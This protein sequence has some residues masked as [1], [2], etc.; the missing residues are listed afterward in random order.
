MFLDFVSQYYGYL[1][2][3][4][5]LGASFFAIGK[6]KAMELVKTLVTEA[7]DTLG[8]HLLTHKDQYVK[9]IYDKIPAKLKVFVSLKMIEKAIVEIAEAIDKK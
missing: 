9:A 5:V 2:A 8:E 7:A 6:K 3:A 4:G 1:I